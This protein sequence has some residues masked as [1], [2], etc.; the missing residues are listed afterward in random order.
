MLNRVKIACV[1]IAV[2]LLTIGCATAGRDT[3]NQAQEAWS[4][5]RPIEALVLATEA[6]L[7]NPE[8]SGAKSFLR[9]NTD[10]GLERVQSFLAS[11]K[12]TPSP[13]DLE[14]RFDNYTG[15]VSFYDNLRQIGMPI[16]EGKRL[17]GLIK[18]WE[19]ST[20]LVDYRPELEESR[21]E[22][23]EGFFTAGVARIQADELDAAAALMQKVVTKFAVDKSD[24]QAQDRSRIANAFVEYA[25]RLHGSIIPEQL[26]NGIK[27]YELALRFE[28]EHSSA[29]AGREVLRNELSEVYL[30]LGL[31]QERRNTID[32]VTE[33]VRYFEEALKY[34]AENQGA[35]DGVPRAKRQLAV[36]YTDQGE[37]QE[38][39]GRVDDMIAAHESYENAL[40]W[41][42]GYQRAADAR[43]AVV[44]RIAEFYYQEG[45][46]LGRN[47]TDANAIAQAITAYENA[48]TWVDGYRDAPLQKQRLHVAR[49]L[50]AMGGALTPIRSQFDQSERRVTGLSR[51]V[52][53]AHKGIADLNNIVDRIAQL[54]EQLGTIDTAS[55]VLAA[56]PVVGSVF[57]VTGTAVRQVQRPVGAVNEKAD[58][59]KDPVI[60]PALR[61]MTTVNERT[62]NVV[63]AMN[64]IKRS[65]DASAA[66]LARLNDCVASIDDLAALAKV[67]QDVK[68]LK[69]AIEEL[70]SGLDRIDAMER[71][72]DA[73]LRALAEAVSLISTVNRGV[74]TVMRPLDTISSV[75]NQINRALQQRVSIPLVGSFTVEE[76]IQS[77]TGVI[78]SAAEAVL[79]PI[80]RQLNIQIPSIPGIDELERLLD[81]VESYYADIR[82]AVAAIERAEAEILAAPVKLGQ[83]TGS[84]AST[85]GCSL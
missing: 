52:N 69:A 37:R 51:S 54:D 68:A 20:P 77:S 79:N 41:D 40:K 7:E 11:S 17:F 8:L 58:A 73:T 10:A 2:A 63:G 61:A 45:A 5:N 35:K 60:E 66:M 13:E 3:L 65:L 42:D 36:L 1:A 24:E 70:R 14:A 47:R 9:D 53:T 85:T 74:E 59:L 55:S 34:N 82:T 64:D 76:A 75:T 57:T 29:A 15:L 84:I 49:E 22:A 23:R 31:E 46:R 80:L 28:A 43:A 21:N 81:S 25:Q 50:I 78:K 6:L 16:A 83:L 48:M 72:I 27:A 19:W 67:E 32:S 33:A 18:S 56:I 30:A 62:D 38:R 44:Q 71:E 26:L 4:A 12:G 39:S